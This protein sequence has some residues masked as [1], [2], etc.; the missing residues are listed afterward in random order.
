MSTY[1]LSLG[2]TPR[3]GRG[4]GGGGRAPT[5][6]LFVANLSTDTEPYTLEEI[7]TGAN[8]VYLPKDRETGEKRGWVDFVTIATMISVYQGL[9]SH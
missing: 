7:F 5:N 3:G 1:P 8:D 4:G 6:K 2:F 9:C